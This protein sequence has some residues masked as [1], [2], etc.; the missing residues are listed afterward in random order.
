M[1][2]AIAELA[3][4]YA[5]LVDGL[6]GPA[7]DA[8]TRELRRLLHVMEA[9]IALHLAAEED[10]LARAEDLPAAPAAQR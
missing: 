7:S 1:H 2:E 3:G 6:D 4:R 10:L 5:A 8:E 9:V